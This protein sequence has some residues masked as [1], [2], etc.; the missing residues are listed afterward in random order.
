MTSIN[1]NRSDA[2]GIHWQLVPLL[3]LLLIYTFKIIYDITLFNTDI[4]NYKSLFISINYSKL[5]TTLHLN[6]TIKITYH[7]LFK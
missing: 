4:L 7:P 1:S 5:N 3:F 6:K 2:R